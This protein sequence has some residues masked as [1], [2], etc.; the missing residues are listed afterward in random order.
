MRPP[1]VFAEVPAA[2]RARIL[3]LLHGPWRTATRMIMIVLSAQGLSAAEIAVL[4]DYDPHTVRRWLRRFATEGLD[5]LGDRP[6]SGRPRLGRP[7]LFRRIAV[8]LKQPG[9]W[10][11]RRIWRHLG[12]P[13]MSLNTL[14]QRVCTL[15]AWRRPRL[16]AKGD[17]AHNRIVANIR[18]RIRRLPAGSV[19]IAEDEAHLDLLPTVRATWVLHSQRMQVMTPGKNRRATIFGALD[20]VTG[21][22]WYLFARRSSAGFIAVLDMLLCAYPT[23]PVVAVICDNDGIH[24]AKKVTTW[25]D[26][27]PRLRLIYGASYSPHDNPVERIWAAMKAHIANTAV[28]FTERIHQARIFFHTRSPNQMLTTAAPQSS[29]WMPTGY[30]QNFSKP[31]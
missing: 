8:L 31:A 14:Y 24:H 17:A 28:T 7:G 23:A 10:T 27:H 19:V 11:I 30:V 6:R 18:R 29:P 13:K 12:C 5:G 15:A 20:L 16:V 21:A 1:E 26:G 3:G 4:L 2:V 25:L 9:P 22:W